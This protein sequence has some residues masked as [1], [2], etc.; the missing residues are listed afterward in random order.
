MLDRLLSFNHQR[1]EDEART[2]PNRKSKSS[3]RKNKKSNANKTDQGMTQD[4]LY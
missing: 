1:H 2:A 3:G 4:S